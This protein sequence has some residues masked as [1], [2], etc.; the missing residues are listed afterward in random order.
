MDIDTICAIATSAGQSGIGVLRLSGSLTSNIAVLVLKRKPKA[1][2]AHYGFFFNKFGKQIDKGV[3]IFFPAPYSFTGEDILELH[4]HGGVIVMQ[5]LLEAVVSMGARVAEAGEFSKRAFLNG[6][7]D[8][9]QAEA[10]ADII[11]ASSKHSAACALRSLSGEFSDQ[12]KTLTNKLIRLRVFIEASIDF[13]DEPLEL[14]QMDDLRLK[15]INIKQELEIVLSS[16]EQGA[17]LRN[18]LTVVI[19]GKPNVGKSSILNAI[20]K[21]KSAIVTDIAGTTRD[22]IRDSVN[23]GG[24]LVNIVDTA[25]I[26]DSDNEI[27]QEGIRRTYKEIEHADVV[28]LVF[29]AKDK[30]A[31]LTILKPSNYNKSLL[32]IKNKIDLTNEEVTISKVNKYTQIALCAKNFLGIN[33]LITE[34]INIAKLDATTENVFLARKRHIIALEAS[35]EAVVSA[36]NQSYNNASELVAEDLRVAAQHLASIVGEFSSDD[37]LGEIFSSF[38]IGK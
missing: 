22:V 25:G 21:V 6:K 5:T 2:Y 18:G 27:E 32:F 13:V 14:M 36:I 24:V 26:C 37:I 19:V 29:E 16:A 30:I 4:G 11:A 33:L 8:L 9:L 34:L 35:L 3:A 1:R 20:T 28:L 12:I 15:I 10:V 31:D 17:I 23:I 38:C 7:M